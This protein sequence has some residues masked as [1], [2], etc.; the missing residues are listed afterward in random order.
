MKHALVGILFW[1]KQIK[2][3]N[4][5]KNP[6]T[7]IVIVIIIFIIVIKLFLIQ[8]DRCAIFTIYIYLYSNIVYLICSQC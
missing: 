2:P 5:K 3:K 4:S 1:N 7:I 8:Y 6:K